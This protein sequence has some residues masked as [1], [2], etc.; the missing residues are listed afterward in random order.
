MKKSELTQD[1]GALAALT[2]E[3]CYV[4]NEDGK[5]ETDLSTGWDAKKVALEEA[6]KEIERRRSEALNKVKSGEVSPIV[7]FM[8]VQLMDL[9][10]L[11]GYTGF[12]KWQIKRHFKP[13]VFQKL[14]DSKL[15]K[16]ASA[17]EISLEELKHF[18]K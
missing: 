7:Y 17:F 2:K 4:K 15:N 5:Y 10:V 12:F 13:S 11:S 8:E 3:V 14:T 6:W 9:T 18:N 16:Y 1:N